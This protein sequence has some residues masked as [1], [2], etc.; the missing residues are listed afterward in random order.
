MTG[1]GASLRTTTPTRMDAAAGAAEGAAAEG[2]AAASG[3]RHNDDPHIWTNVFM[4][5]V[6]GAAAA[7]GMYLF[8][9][10]LLFAAVSSTLYHKSEEES[11]KELDMFAVGAVVAYGVGQTLAPGTMKPGCRLVCVGLAGLIIGFKHVENDEACPE[12]YEKWHPWFHVCCAAFALL[13]VLAGKPLR[14]LACP[15]PSI[16]HA[17]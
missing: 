11:Y 8:T 6:A 16:T 4:L 15:F 17:R 5:C 7:R 1:G 13:V 9:A 3:H 10:A 14:D 2:A 12:R